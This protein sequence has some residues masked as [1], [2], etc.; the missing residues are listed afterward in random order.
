M[1][2]RGPWPPLVSSAQPQRGTLGRRPGLRHRRCPR[3][4]RPRFHRR[5]HLRLRPLRP[6]PP[7][8]GE[9]EGQCQPDPP[10]VSSQNKA[11]LEREAP[12]QTGR[13]LHPRTSKVTFRV[14]VTWFGRVSTDLEFGE[15]VLVTTLVVTALFFALAL[16]RRVRF[17]K[18]SVGWEPCKRI[19][20]G[21][22]PGSGLHPSAGTA[23]GC[24]SQ[25]HASRRARRSRPRHRSAPVVLFR[26]GAEGTSRERRREL[27]H[28]GAQH[29]GSAY[30]HRCDRWCV[31]GGGGGGRWGR[32]ENRSL[33]ARASTSMFSS[34]FCIC[35]RA[36]VGRAATDFQSAAVEARGMSSWSWGK[37][38]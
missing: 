20:V 33:T 32:L 30:A 36:C 27:R 5:C 23:P 3:P 19:R 1:P 15:E 11:S 13:S 28:K 10:R 17:L 18:E 37:T 12:C 38:R 31:G 29:H 8:P 22:R 2:R 34:A 26:A 35:F 21:A 24:S 25:Q 4:R 16:R 9:G 7:L 14:R 6:V